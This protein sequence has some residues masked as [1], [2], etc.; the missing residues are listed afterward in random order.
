MIELKACLAGEAAVMLYLQQRPGPECLHTLHVF[1]Q[2]LRD[3]YADAI[4][5]TQPSYHSL[6]VQLNP[7]LLDPLEFIAGLPKTL[8]P[9]RHQAISTGRLIELPVCYGDELDGG[10]L[11]LVEVS[12][13]TG[14]TVPQVKALHQSQRYLVYAI[15]FAPGFAYLGQL[16]QPLR[17]PRRAT[18]RA[19][20]PKG[21]VAIAEQQTAVYPAVSP[22]GWNLLGLCPVPLFQPQRAGQDEAMPFSHG[23]EVRFYAISQQEFFALGGP[24]DWVLK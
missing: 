21:A 24:R 16:P 19:Q 10:P 12:A 3:R 14:L 5:E 23:D 18:P 8:T 4:T 17:M 1:C 9:V 11:D 2:Q 13:F 6:L 15:G 22:G 7:A 20:V